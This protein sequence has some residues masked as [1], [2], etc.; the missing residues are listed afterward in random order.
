MVIGVIEDQHDAVEE[1]T[2]I[3]AK[4]AL[5]DNIATF[6]FKTTDDHIVRNFKGWYMDLGMVAKHFTVS[7]GALPHRKRQYTI[8][9]TMEM[10][11]LRAL[12]KL[13]KDILD[14]GPG[15][16]IHLDESLF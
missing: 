3:L 14:S 10:N 13:A 1:P 5:T 4:H 12:Y 16:M 9:Q 7:S 11:R 15:S 8:C 2:K 6:T